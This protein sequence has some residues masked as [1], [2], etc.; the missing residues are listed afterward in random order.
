MI[1]NSHYTSKQ[2]TIIEYLEKDWDIYDLKEE[3]KKC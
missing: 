3:K 1:V 2:N